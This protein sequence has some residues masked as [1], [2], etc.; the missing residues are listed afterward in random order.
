MPRE[1]TA[2]LMLH[3]GGQQVE[4]EALREIKTPD[5]IGIWN[6]VDH[7]VVFQTMMDALT[8]SGY[9]VMN[10]VHAVSRKG[11]N[12]F[13]LAQVNADYLETEEYGLV[14]GFR[15]S[16]CKSF[17]ASMVAGAQVFVCDNLAFSGEVSFKHKH[18][19]SVLQ[20][21]PMLFKQ[22]VGKLNQLYLNQETRY[23]AYKV[24]E[25]EDLRAEKIVVDLY[26]DNLITT[27]EVGKI[28]DIYDKPTHDEYGK[29]SAWTLFNAT[30]EVV[31]GKLAR[32]PK[33]TLGLHQTLDNEC[34]AELSGT[35]TA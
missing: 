13:G 20:K 28:I 14:V 23:E 25:L 35:V 5:P 32:L 26:R 8:D 7:T 22:G 24:H 1:L 10:A 9:K 15:N 31:K 11:S 21:L 6:P 29:G 3:C 2:N 4:Y 16:H 19:T 34:V 27:Q 33:T 17:A 18:T 30:T 12:Y